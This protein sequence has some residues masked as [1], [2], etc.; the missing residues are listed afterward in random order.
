MPASKKKT[1]DSQKKRGASAKRKKPSAASRSFFIV[2]IIL[3]FI[4]VTYQYMTGNFKSSLTP[5]PGVKIPIPSE[6][7]IRVYFFNVGQ[8]DSI[9]LQTDENAVLIDAG[10]YSV[11]RELLS[12]LRDAGISTLDYLIATHPHEDH[13]GGMIPVLDNFTVKNV[14]LTEAPGTT[15]SYESFLKFVDEQK[16]PVTFPQA[17]DAI[18]AGLIELNVLAPLSDYS[19]DLNNAS[20]VLRMVYGDTAFLFTGDAE[21]ESE[22]DMLEAGSPLRASVLKIGHHGSR[23]ATTPAFLDAVSPPDAVSPS[24]AVISCG[25]VNSYSHPHEE[26]LTR[27]EERGMQL[28]RTDESGTI[29]MSTDGEKVYLQSSANA[30]E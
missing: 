3:A 25:S 9:L 19:D 20:L 30:G 28:Y 26:V 22:R 21:G 10:E 14:V 8:G 11:R 13:I 2:I 29:I 7:S 27:L 23:A 18:S 1:A 12:Y 17:G 15:A 5:E 6:D 16:I 4:A 24:V